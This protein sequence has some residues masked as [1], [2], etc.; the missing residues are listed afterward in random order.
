MKR[1]VLWQEAFRR[2]LSL[3]SSI[4]CK[5]CASCAKDGADYYSSDSIYRHEYSLCPGNIAVAHPAHDQ[6]EQI[7][8]GGC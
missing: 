7:L 3:L 5:L 6:P 8:Q 4:S 2:R 1:T